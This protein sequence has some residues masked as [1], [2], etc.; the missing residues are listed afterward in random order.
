MSKDTSQ[1]CQPD[2]NSLSVCTNWET[3]G[4][5]Q[6]QAEHHAHR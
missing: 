6:I 3:D 4:E 5:R 2:L 1:G